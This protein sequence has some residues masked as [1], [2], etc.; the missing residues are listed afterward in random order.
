[1]AASPSDEQDARRD[2]LPEN[3]NWASFGLDPM[4]LTMSTINTDPETQPE[5]ERTGED[6]EKSLS[7]WICVVGA[8]LFLVPTFGTPNPHHIDICKETRLISKYQPGF[9]SSLGT[10][11]SHLSNNQLRDYTEDEVGWISGMFLFV[12][13]L[14]NVQVGPILDVH[15][16]NIIGPA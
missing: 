15:G 7:A 1:M 5:E 9:M 3:P 4:V 8:F 16:P 14:L 11:Q 10:V 6:V 2:S 13:L 12:S